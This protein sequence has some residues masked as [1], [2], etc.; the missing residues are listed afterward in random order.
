MAIVNCPECKKE[1]SDKARSCPHCGCPLSENE[2]KSFNDDILCCP[3]CMS[4]EL[5]AEKSGFSG[6]KATVGLAL[7]GTVGLLAGTIGSRDIKITC[8]KCGNQFNAGEARIVKN[9]KS[10]SNLDQ[11]IIAMLCNG[12]TVGATSLYRDETKCEYSEAQSHIYKLLVDEVPKYQTPEQ[13]EKIRQEYENLKEKKGCYVATSI[14][15]SYNCP[16]VWILRRFRDDTLDASWFGR[17]FIKIYYAVSPTL[18]K[19]FG[20]S[21]IFKGIFTPILDNMVKSLKDKGISDKPYND[22]Y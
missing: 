5:H 2:S 16:Q 4:R 1:V 3:K 8:L 19:W 18:V 11:R 12:D 9:G 22:K 20:E 7:V 14:Y 13:K 21:A 15:G 17:C 6:G 10:A